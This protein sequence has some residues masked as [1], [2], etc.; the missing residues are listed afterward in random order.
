MDQ[1]IKSLGKGG[2]PV[3]RKKKLRFGTVNG[4]HF[5][6]SALCWSVSV[7]H[8]SVHFGTVYA[9]VLPFGTV[10]SRF[11]TVR[12]TSALCPCL[13]STIRFAVK[14]LFTDGKELS[15]KDVKACLED[16]LPNSNIKY[17]SSWLKAVKDYAANQV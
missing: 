17:N 7:R 15:N 8:C 11:G 4:P 13:A 2:D 16:K 3:N 12:N 10:P 14:H 1:S 9:R 5:Y 6:H